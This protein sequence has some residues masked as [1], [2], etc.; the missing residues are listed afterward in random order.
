MNVSFWARPNCYVKVFSQKQCLSLMFY[1][2]IPEVSVNIES[3]DCYDFSTLKQI[4]EYEFM[5]A[6]NQAL[7]SIE[8]AM[9]DKIIAAL[10]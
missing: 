2:A 4:S 1:S 7:A 5:S 8:A 9:K 3:V 6:F 10:N